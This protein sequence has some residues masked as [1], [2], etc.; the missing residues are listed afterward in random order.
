MNVCVGR[1]VSGGSIPEETVNVRVLSEDGDEAIGRETFHE[2]DI[3]IGSFPPANEDYTPVDIVL[4]FHPENFT[5]CFDVRATNDSIA[6][7]GQIFFLKLLVDS[8]TVSSVR[9][10]IIDATPGKSPPH[11]GDQCRNVSFFMYSVQGQ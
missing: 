10:H 3:L 4:E 1:S 2:L 5:I 9:V 11:H 7:S 6:E 8:E